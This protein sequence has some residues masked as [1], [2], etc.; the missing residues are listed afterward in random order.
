[1][2]TEFPF[3]W[4]LSSRKNIFSI[5]NLKYIQILEKLIIKYSKQDC[6]F[7]KNIKFIEKTTLY[8]NFI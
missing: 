6:L 1:M 7:L 3:K 2:I 8:I 5:I 4:R